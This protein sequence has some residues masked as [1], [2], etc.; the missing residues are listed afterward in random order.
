M[1]PNLEKKEGLSPW[2]VGETPG[3]YNASPPAEY[4]RHFPRKRIDEPGSPVREG[5]VVNCR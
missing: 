4:P 2:N 5:G 1:P 3:D